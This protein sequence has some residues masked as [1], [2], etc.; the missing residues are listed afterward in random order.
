M[1]GKRLATVA[2]AALALASCRGGDTAAPQEGA[3]GIKVDFGV[4][5]EPCPQPVDS[6][7]GCIYLG[8]ISDLTEGPF[9]TL[10][11][12]IT[13]A[14]KAFWKRVNDQGG[15]GG[16]EVDVTKYVKD[17][18]YN[19]QIQ[20]QVY[21]EIKGNI[22]ALTQT[23]GS[24]TTVAIL[25]DLQS[26]N[27][28]SVPASWTSLWGFEEVILESGANYCIESMNTV[29]Y[30]ADKLGAKSVMAVHLA[31]DYGDDA[32]AGAKIAAE[33]RGLSFESVT[34]QT[35]Q[36]NQAGA[37][38]AVVSKKP[39]L[40]VLTTGP[41]DAAVIIGQTAARGYQGKFIGTSPTW[42]PGLLQS[43]AAPAIKALYLQSAPW[44]A[45]NTE[46]VGH[47]A[48]RAGLSGV[49]PNDG[50]TAGWVWAYPLKAALRKAA[51]NKDLTRAGVVAAVRQLTSVDY[52]GM[53]PSGAGNFS[54]SPQEAAFRQTLLYQPDEAAPTGVS[55]VE[56]FFTGPTAKDFTLD[57]PCYQ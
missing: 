51:E 34:T 2:V 14:Q 26:S 10:A 46:S 54:A 29:D 44:K 3:G 40:V 50:Y 4:T 39:D 23:L 31:G 18:K 33:K 48:M 15:I 28:V 12:P 35:G 9:K 17:N 6:S 13:D 36:D 53:L 43:P 41:T 21:Q 25:P 52:E 7:K 56:D 8:T 37:I 47:T 32:A 1:S 38:D 57:K 27:I 22:L 5:A 20:N 19:P 45:W 30:A 42:N 11:V 55:L 16:Y 49:T 24:P